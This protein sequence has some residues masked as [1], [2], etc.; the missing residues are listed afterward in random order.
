MLIAAFT[1]ACAVCPRTDHKRGCR[2]SFTWTD[3]RALLTTAH[4]QLGAPIV[5]VW[6]TL[7]VHRDTR[8]RTFIDAYDCVTSY[9]LPTYA[10]DRNPVEGIRSLLRRSSQAN[11]SG[12]DPGFWTPER[13]GS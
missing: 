9:N 3:Y 13:L 11:T 8:L 5:L 4:Q 2:R 12:L 1:S 10:P 7:N 6:D